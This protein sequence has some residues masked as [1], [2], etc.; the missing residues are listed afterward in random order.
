MSKQD[1]VNFSQYLRGKGWDDNVKHTIGTAEE[2]NKARLAILEEEKAITKKL[3]ELA[4]KRQALPWVEI[5]NANSYVLHGTDGKEVKLTDFF[6]AGVQDLIVYHMMFADSYE[7]PCISCSCWVDNLN[8]VWPHLASKSNV[9]VIAKAQY[10]RLADVK[11]EK[12]WELP[13]Y[14]SAG[15]TFNHDF[16]AEFLDEDKGK[17]V[18]NH[19]TKEVKSA[20]QN[21]A[22]SIFRKVGDKVYLTYQTTARGLEQVNSVFSYFNLLPD[23]RGS[24]T[25][26]HKADYPKA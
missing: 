15:T 11:K 5:P 12:A 17:K 2:H 9:A 26:D 24:W 3:D 1:H 4:R 21:P 20:G 23:G 13:L 16:H 6:R 14:S 25:P 22:V 8:G 18:A 19:G 10:S 7:K